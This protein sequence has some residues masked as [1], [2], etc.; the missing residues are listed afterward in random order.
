M[1]DFQ[2]SILIYNQRKRKNWRL[3]TCAVVNNCKCWVECDNH[4]DCCDVA[5]YEL[6]NLLARKN[7]LLLRVINLT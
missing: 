1:A 3:V 6:V 4:S 5:L 2:L 7:I